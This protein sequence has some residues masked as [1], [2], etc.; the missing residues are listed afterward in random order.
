MPIT[1]LRA[2]NFII[3]KFYI[4]DII[5]ESE[6]DL[7]FYLDSMVLMEESNQ[8]DR[9][10]CFWIKLSGGRL[11]AY[12]HT[13]RGIECRTFSSKEITDAIFYG[14]SL[15]FYPVEKIVGLFEEPALA[16]A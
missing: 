11:R 14:K 13:R 4:P 1:V 15:F 3:S 8:S 7:R 9:S 5:A 2:S 16:V 12:I 10:L 6:K